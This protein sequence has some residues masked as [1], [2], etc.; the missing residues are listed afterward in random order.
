MH[1][2]DDIARSLWPSGRD[3]FS[4]P[5]LV[6]IHFYFSSLLVLSKM[7]QS[8][9]ERVHTWHMQDLASSPLLTSL[10]ILDSRNVD[11]GSVAANN[12]PEF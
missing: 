10:T 6:G 2:R 12:A 4:S 9:F 7:L 5:G 1:D 8:A 11:R 3:C